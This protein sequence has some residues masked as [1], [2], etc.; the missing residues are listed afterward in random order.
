MIHIDLNS[1][2]PAQNWFDLVLVYDTALKNQDNIIITVMTSTPTGRK[3][4]DETLD[5]SKVSDR[6]RLY[7]KKEDLWNNDTVQLKENFFESDFIIG[8][9]CW[10]SEVD[11]EGA[12]LEIEHFRPKNEINPLDYVKKGIISNELWLFLDKIKDCQVNR[13][14]GYYWLTY[15]WTNYKLS[16]RITNNRKGNYFPL[17][18]NSIP[19][20]QYGEEVN[21]KP[22][23]L[24]PCI[25]D[26]AELIIFEKRKGK[27]ITDENGNKLQT[28]EVYAIPLVTNPEISGI[29]DVS[30]HLEEE[31]KINLLRALVSIWVYELNDMKKIKSSRAKIWNETEDSLKEII[32]NNLKNEIELFKKIQALTHK[33]AKHCGVARQVV[34]EYFDSGRITEEQYKNCFSPTL[35]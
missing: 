5:L 23:L 12:E 22:V 18:P 25:K 3:K 17:L 26:E 10:F 35:P 19:A 16:C 9:K 24:N 1:Q 4:R 29:V 15:D 31:E 27:V 2:Q 11:S 20:T 6:K 34:R 14:E 21:E 13:N 8:S 7:D 32:N 33:T 28:T 30:I